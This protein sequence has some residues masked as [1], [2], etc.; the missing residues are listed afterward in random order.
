MITPEMMARFYALHEHY[1]GMEQ[2]YY[3]NEER[4][5]EIDRSERALWVE[6]YL[7][8]GT[9]HL[10]ITTLDELETI[11]QTYTTAALLAVKPGF[12]PAAGQVLDDAHWHETGSP[13]SDP[14]VR[15][16]GDLDRY[17]AECG[18]V[19]ELLLPR[20]EDAPLPKDIQE[21]IDLYDLD[22]NRHLKIDPSRLKD[23][24]FGESDEDARRDPASR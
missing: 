10:P 2:G 8:S 20:P 9:Q 3:E 4:L 14:H 22:E 17:G 15:W 12:D 7:D 21:L 18:L 19:M 5:L 24:D 11:S 1:T 16:V 6:L 23:F 13:F